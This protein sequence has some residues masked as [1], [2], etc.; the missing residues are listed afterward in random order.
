LALVGAV[1][2][3]LIWANEL[4]Q[5]DDENGA[6]GNDGKRPD[7]SSRENRPV[8]PPGSASVERFLDRCTA[9]QLCVSVCPT[10]VLQPSSLHDGVAGML[11][12]HL[13]FPASY[14][15]YD[16]K[17]CGE[18]CPSGALS[19]LSLVEKRRTRI[20]LARFDASRCVVETK[21]TACTLCIDH[22]PVKAI[23]SVA[24]SN[25]LRLPQVMALQCIGCGRCEHECPVQGRKAITVFGL[26]RETHVPIDVPG[27]GKGQNAHA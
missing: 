1:G 21:R 5:Y 19:A 10:H 4:K 26:L 13:D 25:N 23:E 14:C 27:E 12:P 15:D 16:C 22:C 3:E 7:A 8:R 6:A 18:A 2:S 20:G 17:R 9:C 24:I 11:K